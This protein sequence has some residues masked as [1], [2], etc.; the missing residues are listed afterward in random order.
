M[1][2]A[3]PAERIRLKP[4]AELLG[5]HAET[6]RRWARD[7]MVRYWEVGKGRYMEF[8][9]RDIAALDQSFVRD[10]PSQGT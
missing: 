5:V 4:A 3:P 6:L 8:D 1:T 7:G 9:P 10:V 2:E